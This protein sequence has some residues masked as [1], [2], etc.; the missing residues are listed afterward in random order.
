MIDSVQEKKAA[1]VTVLELR[2]LTSLTDYFVLC[3]GESEPQIKT[4][5]K[6]V[7]EKLKEQGITPHHVE[8]T[9]ESGWLLLDY[10]DFVVH[11][12]SPQKRTY[13]E[14]DRLWADAPRME[15]TDAKPSSVAV[16]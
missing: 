16:R 15:L 10:D 6:N 13:Y 8:G 12:F 4:I 7:Q 3:N 2:K 11:I 5:V 9:A 14:L 1:E